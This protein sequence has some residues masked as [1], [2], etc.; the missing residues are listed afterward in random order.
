MA[1]RKTYSAELKAQAV[2]ELLR[3]EK[4]LT[5]VASEYGVHPNQLRRWKQT[6]LEQLPSLFTRDSAAAEQLAE[7]AALQEQLY[8]EIGRLTQVNWLKI[9][10][11]PPAG[12]SGNIEAND[13]LPLS[14]QCELVGVSRRV[15][16]R[17]VGASPL[18]LA[19]KRRIDEITRL[20]RSTAHVG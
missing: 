13:D 5:Q 19:L 6:A 9:W 17:P 8:A 15:D 11:R 12:A 7:Q 1:K 2:L 10:C 3:E 20:T 18:E 14:V 16:Y 4:S